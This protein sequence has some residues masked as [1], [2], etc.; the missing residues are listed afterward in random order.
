MLTGWKDIVAYTG[1]SRF[2]IKR[3]RKEDNFPLQYIADRP[4]TTKTLI[5]KWMEDRNSKTPQT[6]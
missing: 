3:L 2:T 5:E 1:L 4:T 6:Q